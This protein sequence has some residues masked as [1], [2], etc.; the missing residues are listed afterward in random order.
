MLVQQI[1]IK[2]AARIGRELPPVVAPEAVRRLMSYSW[3]GNIRE[4]E[5]VIERAIV[6]CDGDKL[7][8]TCLPGHCPEESAPLLSADANLS[9]KQAERAMEIDLIRKA[10]LK[11]GGNRTHAAKELEISH[12]ALL[13]KLKEYELE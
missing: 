5:N 8:E 1:V 12:R 11:T 7:S 4:L 13:Y 9:I 10:L 3:P 6:L 2:C